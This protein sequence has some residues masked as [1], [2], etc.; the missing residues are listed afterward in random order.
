L[1]TFSVDVDTA[2]YAN[3]HR[4]LG[5]GQAPPADAVRV[6]ELI[7]YFHHP[8]PEPV[9]EHPVAV[10]SEVGPC[11]WQAEHRLVRLGLKAR[12]LPAHKLPPRNLTFLIDVSGSMGDPR[13]L[14]LL[15]RAFGLLIDNL[16][17]SDRVAIVVYAGASGLVLPPTRGTQKERI[18]H[19]LARRCWPARAASPWASTTISSPPICSSCA[20]TSGKSLANPSLP[21]K[22]STRR[23]SSMKNFLAR[24]S[25]HEPPSRSCPARRAFARG[26][27]R[28]PHAHPQPSRRNN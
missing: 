24:S 6:E 20:A 8:Y 12:A 13:K 5:D 27:C 26:L 28:V 7:N 10:H 18:R 17:E 11:P 14:P 21:P 1:S 25:I 4:F 3:V 19:T 9:D 16:T 2:S 22:I 23:S 15:K